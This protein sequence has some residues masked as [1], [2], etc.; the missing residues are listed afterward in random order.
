MYNN[1]FKER[2]PI[3]YISSVYCLFV[4]FFLPQ[5][6][7]VDA[8]SRPNFEK[9]VAD[10]NNEKRD[11]TITNI[12]NDLKMRWKQ[13]LGDIK[14]LIHDLEKE[15]TSSSSSFVWSLIK[16]YYFQPTEDEHRVTQDLKAI[17]EYVGNIE[18]SL[19]GEIVVD[20]NFVKTVEIFDLK[21]HFKCLYDNIQKAEETVK[22]ELKD[23][24]MKIH[25]PVLD[26]LL[27]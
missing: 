21:K 12:S 20:S 8:N 9:I 18:A 17:T 27:C 24:T 16:A 3:S 26:L 19:K 6:L 11:T 5:S 2:N 22:V 4:Y 10:L 15:L 25:K 1:N 7:N 23:Y 13:M 14:G